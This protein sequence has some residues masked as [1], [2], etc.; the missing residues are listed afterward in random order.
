M[1][2]IDKILNEWSFRCHDGIVDM[3]DP[4]K[5]SILKEIL[6]EEGIDD[7]ILDATLNLPK[8]DPASEEK[9]RKALAVLTGISGDEKDKEEEKI[10]Q[11]KTFSRGI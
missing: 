11:I 6:I 1:N 10:K 7:D 4:K 8:D 5:V 3:N 2:V 9:K